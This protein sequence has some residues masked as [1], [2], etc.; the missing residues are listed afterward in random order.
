MSKLTLFWREDGVE[1]SQVI[2]LNHPSS[3]KAGTVSLG[4]EP[5]DCDLVLHD[6]RISRLHAEITFNPDQRKFYIQNLRETNPILVDNQQLVRGFKL[7]ENGTIIT[8]GETKVRVANIEIASVSVK[9]DSLVKGSS[10]RFSLF[11]PLASRGKDFRQKAYLIPGIVTVIWVVLLFSSIGNQGF[12]NFLL[13]TY[14]GGGGFY[15][16]YQLCG[17]HKPWWVLS[18]PVLA[19]P[20]LL[21]TPVWLFIAFVFR[22]I[23]PG[24]IP[25]QPTDFL[26]ALIAFFFGAGLA[27]ELLKAL[28]IFAMSWFTQKLKPSWREKV[29]VTEP[30]DGI[31]LGAASGLGFT[32]LETL[33][34]YVPNLVGNVSQELGAGVGEL[35]GLQLLIPRIV[36]SVFGHMAYSGYFGYYIGL[37]NLKP[38]RRWQFLWT[39]YLISAGI[40]AL[41]NSSSALGSWASVLVGI[42]AYCLL[43]G[44]ILKARQLSPTRS[45]SASLPKASRG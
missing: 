43:T 14:L 28:P 30:L 12:F 8:L 21:L 31:M 1:R 3:K 38:K 33:G 26:S 40:H 42:L 9:A 23:L 44:A 16:I 35:S 32:L 6:P 18:I 25:E 34:Q 24:R 2:D 4:R 13:A 15:F 11:L 19:T 17:K 20:V 37:S 5:D 39:G 29:G 7:L 36:G 10:T 22:G 27:E 41:W 45:H